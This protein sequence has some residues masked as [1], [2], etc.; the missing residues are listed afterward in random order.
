MAGYVFPLESDGLESV[1][2]SGLIHST[3]S[4]TLETF[5]ANRL[6]KDAL[7]KNKTAKQ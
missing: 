1:P 3:G 2:I 4:V 6:A 7:A 5:C